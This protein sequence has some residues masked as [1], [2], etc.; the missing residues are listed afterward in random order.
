MKKVFWISVL[1]LG[2]SACDSSSNTPG[3]NIVGEPLPRAI[4]LMQSPSFAQCTQHRL[5]YLPQSFSVKYIAQSQTFATTLGREETCLDIP[6]EEHNADTYSRYEYS[7]D[8]YTFT[9]R[10]YAYGGVYLGREDTR[11]RS[12]KRADTRTQAYAAQSGKEHRQWQFE[13]TPHEEGYV[14]SF[15]YQAYN[16]SGKRV[17]NIKSDNAKRYYTGNGYEA[18]RLPFTVKRSDW[19][20]DADYLVINQQLLLPERLREGEYVLHTYLDRYGEPKGGRL[21]YEGAFSLCYERRGKHMYAFNAHYW[22]GCEGDMVGVV[23]Y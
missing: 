9:K 22:E 17:V 3:S 4:T 14:Q 12:N 20:E 16:P 5:A 11:I 21:E 6:V 8:F 7:D 18:V 19:A 15:S 10:N 13:K 2:L 1:A 23:S